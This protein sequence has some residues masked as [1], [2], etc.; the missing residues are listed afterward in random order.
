MAE[1]RR[2]SDPRGEKVLGDTHTVHFLHTELT[3]IHYGK[4]EYSASEI[5]ALILATDRGSLWQLKSNETSPIY[6]I[7]LLYT[8]KS[9]NEYK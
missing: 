2:A 8:V 1:I 4:P 9:Q 3:V 7:V 5:T 6:N